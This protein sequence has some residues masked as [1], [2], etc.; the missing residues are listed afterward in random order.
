MRGAAVQKARL[1]KR[2]AERQ[3][4]LHTSAINQAVP[5]TESPQ[6][7]SSGGVLSWFLGERPTTPVPALYEP[8]EGVN[9]PPAL[10]E[11]IKPSQTKVTTLG[12]GLRIASE[13][14]SGPTSTIGIFID[15]GSKNESP[16][17]TGASHLLERMAFKSTVNRSHFRLV[18]EME[19]IGG[20]VMANASRETMCYTGDAIKTF[21]PELVE[22]LV[23]TVRNPL[24]NE[25]EVQEQLAKVKAETAEAVHNPQVMLYEALHSAGFIGGLGQPLMAPESTLGRLNGGVLHDFV[26]ENYTAPRIVLAA[27][28]VDHEDLLSVAEPLL[29]D[30]PS[31]DKSIPVETQYV[32]GDWRQSVDSPLTHVAIAFEVPGGW[33]NEKDSYAVTVLQQ[34]LGG[35]GSFS[36]GGPGKGMYSRLYTRVL[37]RWEQVQSFTAFNSIYNDTGLF[38]IHATSSGEFVPK[39]VDLACE[40]LAAVATPGQVTEAELQRA[41]NSTISAVLMNLES[42]VVIT[43][44]IGRQILTYGHRKPVAEF[45][46]GVQALTL[47][48]IANV[49]EKIVSTSLTM[50]SWG[51]VVQVPRFDAVADRF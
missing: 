17:C 27:S 11:D 33:R 46:Q 19:A 32:G 3:L 23:D 44:D 20:N 50:A 8:L 41:K 12:N 26:K 2:L 38:G 4:Q 21:M 48:D 25:W 37:N 5:R 24:F 49:S 7:S 14:V 45:I 42:R 40:E 18:R 10:P 22:L 16:F 39:L 28:G 6:A 13:N 36:A 1:V 30:L 9:L 35:G 43:E 15:S 34:L 29:A 51:N 31:S 47:E